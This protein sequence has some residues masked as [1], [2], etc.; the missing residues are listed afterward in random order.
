MER[1]ESLHFSRKLF[2]WSASI[3]GMLVQQWLMQ[4]SPTVH[5]PEVGDLAADDTP[6]QREGNSRSKGWSESLTVVSSIITGTKDLSPASPPQTTKLGEQSIPIVSVLL[7]LKSSPPGHNPWMIPPEWSSLGWAYSELSLT[8]KCVRNCWC[9]YG[10]PSS[11]LE[12]PER[13]L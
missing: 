3:S 10:R 4:R 6:L 1:A 8:H 2:C 13:R 9:D 5:P 12:L 11:S 7:S